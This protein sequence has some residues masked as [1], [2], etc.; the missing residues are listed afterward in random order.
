MSEGDTSESTP[1][2]DDPPDGDERYLLRNRRQIR[3]LLKSLIDQRSLV[4]AH[5]G[6][7]D[8][9]FPTAVLELDED[10]EWVLLDASHNEAVNR[11]VE[12]AGHLLCFAQ[13]DHVRVR[14]RLDAPERIAR[15]GHVGFRA[16]LPQTLYHLQRRE[17]YRLATPI[18]ESPTCVIQVT[19]ATGRPVE[20]RLRV[21][22][23]SGGGLAVNLAPGMPLLELHRTYPDCVL[24]LPDCPP[25]RVPLTI[26]SQYQQTLPN[27]TD[28]Y[29]IGVRFGALPRGADESIQRYIFRVDRQRSARKSGVF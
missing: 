10:G 27:G 4:S 21:I 18:T 12:G 6:G 19:A 17:F 24:E 11:A 8:Q 23:I 26:C 15:E 13:L 1:H 3:G 9:S 7:R 5:L 22:D 25:I 28:S 16:A 20:L 14:F 2:P 29:R